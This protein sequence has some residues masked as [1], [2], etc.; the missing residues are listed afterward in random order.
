MPVRMLYNEMKTEPVPLVA[1]MYKKIIVPAIDAKL[2]PAYQEMITPLKYNYKATDSEEKSLFT[3]WHDV[4]NNLYFTKGYTDIFKDNPIAGLW[5]AYEALSQI[6]ERY[7]GPDFYAS[8]M[9][10]FTY[11]RKKFWVTEE[12]G[13]VIFSTPDDY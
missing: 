2:L 6:F 4:K 9:Q 10:V 8:Y 12:G 1:D 3:E 7:P 11:K 13:Q 5:C